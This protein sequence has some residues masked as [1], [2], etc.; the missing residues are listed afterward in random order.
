MTRRAWGSSLVGVLFLAVS[1]LPASA[2]SLTSSATT[3]SATTSTRT[4]AVSAAA[5]YRDQVTKLINQRRIKVGCKP[6]VANYPLFVAAY[7][8][9]NRM[10][11]A[12]KLSHQLPGE[13]SLGVRATQAGYKGWRKLAENLAHGGTTPWSTYVLWMQSKAHRVNIENCFY[14]DLGLAVGFKHGRPWLTADFGRRG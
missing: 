6:L 10:M 3:S 7:K 11:A 14:K 5:Q 9:N 2:S 4:T 13:P 8:H 12:H 1:V